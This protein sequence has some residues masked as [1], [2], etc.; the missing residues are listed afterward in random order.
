MSDG[1][2][3]RL[4]RQPGLKPRVACDVQAL[5]TELRDTARDHVFDLCGLDAGALDDL[6]VGLGH[7]SLGWVFLV[8]PFSLC[9]RP[10][11]V[12]IAST[13]T[14]ARPSG[15]GLDLRSRGVACVAVPRF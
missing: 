5:L 1:R 8:V 15:G 3:R 9:P 7:S 14:G 2:T 10:I 4:D 13:I 11:G 6:G 12:R